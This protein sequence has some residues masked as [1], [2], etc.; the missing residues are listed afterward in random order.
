[1]ALSI[2]YCA[3][4]GMFI[5]YQLRVETRIRSVRLFDSG[6]ALVVLFALYAEPDLETMILLVYSWIGYFWGID[7]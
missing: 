1:M 7:V 2:L 5:G 6:T 4:A 3:L